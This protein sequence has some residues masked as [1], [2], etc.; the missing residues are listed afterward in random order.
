MN[1]RRLSYSLIGLGLLLIAK[2]GFA[3]TKPANNTIILESNDSLPDTHYHGSH[4]SHCSHSS[5]YSSYL[6]KSTPKI[7]VIKQDSLSLV[8]LDAKFIDNDSLKCIVKAYIADVQ[9]TDCVNVNFNGKAIVVVVK[10]DY[11]N[12]SRSPRIKITSHI[13]P[14][15]IS[16]NRYFTSNGHL[17]FHDLNSMYLTLHE[18][19]NSQFNNNDW[20]ERERKP[21]MYSFDNNFYK[22][23]LDLIY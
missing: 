11:G 4:S 14:L 1:I 12:Y 18:D 19:L 17:G 20:L 5:H 2:L 21:W 23:I 15:D 7:H 8:T 22:N 3:N 10:D 9:I 6:S 13:I 16:D